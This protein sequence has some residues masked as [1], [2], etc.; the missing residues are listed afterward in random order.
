M[1][2]IFTQGLPYLDS[3]EYAL[4]VVVAQLSNF[5]MYGINLLV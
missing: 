1:Q 3:L 4:A 5:M 2:Q